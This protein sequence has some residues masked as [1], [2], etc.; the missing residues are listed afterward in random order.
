MGT[1]RK[2]LFTVAAIALPATSALV[3]GTPALFAGATTPAFPVTCKVG[4]DI[5]FTPALTKTGTHTTNRAAATTV[6]ITS[7]KLSG[8]LSGASA[9]APNKGTFSA[10]ISLPATSIGRI[11][12]VKTYATGY[13]PAF[14]QASTLKAVRKLAFVVAWTKGE[15]GESVFTTKQVISATNNELPPEYGWIL[16]GKE[17]LGSYAQRSLNQF[18]LYFDGTDSAALQTG[19][20]ASQT[21]GSATFDSSN[22]VGTL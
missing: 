20:S 17:G 2:V 11:G 19:C 12:G 8:C 1:R 10:T 16:S 7:G 18:D 4:A 22:S 14:T 21:V 9:G 15:A 13:C 6:A 5:T 3:F